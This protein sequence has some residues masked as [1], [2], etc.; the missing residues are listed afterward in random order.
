MRAIGDSGRDR[1]RVGIRHALLGVSES[2]RS[3]PRSLSPR[4]PY[5]RARQRDSGV[6]TEIRTVPSLLTTTPRRRTP[7]PNSRGN[8]R[9]RTVKNDSTDVDGLRLDLALSGER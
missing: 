4:S 9:P 6:P 7:K 1:A 2:A 5:S 8:P 3:A